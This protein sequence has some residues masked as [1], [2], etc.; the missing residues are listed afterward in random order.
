MFFANETVKLYCAG[1]YN[2]T[3]VKSMGFRFIRSSPVAESLV[4]SSKANLPRLS[5]YQDLSDQR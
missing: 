3:D 4:S 2:I 5:P 1:R